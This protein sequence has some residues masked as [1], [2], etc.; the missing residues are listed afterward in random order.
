MIYCHMPCMAI[1]NTNDYSH[2]ST[3]LADS[4]LNFIIRIVFQLVTIRQFNISFCCICSFSNVAC[5]IP[6]KYNLHSTLILISYWRWIAQLEL[7]W[8]IDSN[9]SSVQ[10]STNSIKPIRFPCEIGLFRIFLID[11]CIHP[12]C[13]SILMPQ[14]KKLISLK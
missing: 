9:L 10:Q 1:V 5:I 4:Q 6:N 12:E 14:K 8:L 2:Y 13:L 7:Y 11:F 3:A